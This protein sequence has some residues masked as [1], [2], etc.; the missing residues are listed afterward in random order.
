MTPEKLGRTNPGHF[1]IK[2]CLKCRN[3]ASVVVAISKKWSQTISPTDFATCID[4]CGTSNFFNA[5]GCGV[6]LNPMTSRGP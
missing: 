4:C 5:Q 3:A 2:N 6:R 1:H